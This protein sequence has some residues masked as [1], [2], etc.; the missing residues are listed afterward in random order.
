MGLR[1]RSL[2]AVVLRCDRCGQP[3]IWRDRVVTSCCMLG[4]A[5]CDSCESSGLHSKWWK[6]EDSYWRDLRDDLVWLLRLLMFTPRSVK[7]RLFK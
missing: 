3:A 7:Q 5:L 2:G 1:R 6:Q 4:E